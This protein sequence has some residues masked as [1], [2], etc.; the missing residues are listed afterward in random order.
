MDRLGTRRRYLVK[1]SQVDSRD[2]LY[3][4][5]WDHQVYCTLHKISE[6]IT[7]NIEGRSLQSMIGCARQGVLHLVSAIFQ[8]RVLTRVPWNRTSLAKDSPKRDRNRES[9]ICQ[10][11]KHIPFGAFA[12]K[13]AG[14]TVR[15]PGRKGL[16]H[17]GQNP[18]ITV[19]EEVVQFGDNIYFTGFAVTLSSFRVLFS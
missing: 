12:E 15:H 3:P 2:F 14:V 4:D 16:G 19:Y 10:A 11:V 7:Y 8:P 5:P 1:R 18:F 9:S 17:F 6:A 13:V